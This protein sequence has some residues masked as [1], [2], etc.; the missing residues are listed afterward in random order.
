MQLLKKICLAFA[1]LTP[2]TFASGAQAAHPAVIELFTS[3]GCSSCPPADRLVGSLADN[4]DILVL[5]FHVDYWN[6]L[7]WKDPFSSAQFTERQ[8]DYAQ[9]LGGRNVYT[10]QAVIQG[11]YDVVGS[12][13]GRLR[14]ALD[15]AHESKDWVDVTLQSSSNGLSI[16]LPAATL[17]NATILLVGY[18]KKASTQ[19]ARGEN[20]G[21]NLTHRNSV[22]ALQTLGVWQGE[23]WKKTIAKPTGD[24]TAVLIQSN[25]SGAIIGAGWL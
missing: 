2:M 17:R 12:S 3:Q 18:D 22:R 4:P 19:V 21:E 13:A 23:S 6:Y 20:A 15:K 25:T 24:G 8:R 16:A 1:A 14:Q 5:S 7:G 11:T 9:F 10:P